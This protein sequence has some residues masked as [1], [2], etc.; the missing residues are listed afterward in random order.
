MQDRQNGTEWGGN[1]K[2]ARQGSETTN[3]EDANPLDPDAEGI[4]GGNVDTSSL[5]GIG[6]GGASLAIEKTDGTSYSA[7]SNKQAASD[8]TDS[9]G[10]LRGNAGASGLGTADE[11]SA[12]LA[13]NTLRTSTIGSRSS[14]HDS[15]SSNGEA[16]GAWDDQ[17]E[18]SRNAGVGLVADDAL[19]ASNAADALEDS[20][21]GGAAAGALPGGDSRDGGA[22]AGG[23]GHSSVVAGQSAATHSS[24]GKAAGLATGRKGSVD[25][26][27]AA[28]DQLATTSDGSARSKSAERVGVANVGAGDFDDE[29]D[30]SQGNLSSGKD[31]VSV[32][33]RSADDSDRVSTSRAKSGSFNRSSSSDV[34][35]GVADS[36]NRAAKGGT[37]FAIDI[38]R[39]DVGRNGVFDSSVVGSSGSSAGESAAQPD[40]QADLDDEFH[41][42]KG[43][44]GTA[45]G[46]SGTSSSRGGS[47]EGSSS[48]KGTSSAAVKSAGHLDAPLNDKSS[49]AHR[50]EGGGDGSRTGT[51]A[52]GK[53]ATM[54]DE[55][56]DG[57]SVDPSASNS[58][59]ELQLDNDRCRTPPHP[60]EPPLHIF[61]PVPC[62]SYPEDR[63]PS[64]SVKHTGLDKK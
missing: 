59:N 1:L 3:A 24:A 32:T 56:P 36:T 64:S 10:G 55:K 30:R 49:S 54:S 34:G 4:V 14:S 48:K 29:V 16:L 17:P 2:V 7:R 37:S 12:I 57:L 13:A 45:K 11:D 52:V 25:Q 61:P 41:G 50:A 44:R 20:S 28:S 63:K 23:R 18:G 19:A 31:S 46:S 6:S 33:G 21:F 9:S 39:D 51:T 8:G 5:G 47:R 38:N 22:D 62:C 35:P 26:A 58:D 43:S 15:S 42:P 40:G 53:P 60:A 27:K